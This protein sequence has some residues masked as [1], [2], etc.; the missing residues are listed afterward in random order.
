ML[1]ADFSVLRENIT[2]DAVSN[3]TEAYVSKDPL[4]WVKYNKGNKCICHL[5]QL[6]D[7]KKATKEE[8]AN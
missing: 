8:F 1:G 7:P 3:M 5:S 6:K 2:Q 4:V